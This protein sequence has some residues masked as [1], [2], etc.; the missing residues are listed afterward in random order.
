LKAGKQVEKG[1][2]R[3]EGEKGKVTIKTGATKK[4]VFFH[5]KTNSMV[6]KGNREKQN[7]EGRGK[8]YKRVCTLEGRGARDS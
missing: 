6:T 4:V 1:T 8:R 5:P 3:S 7:N 2:H